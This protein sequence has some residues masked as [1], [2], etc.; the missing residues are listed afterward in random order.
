MRFVLRTLTYHAGNLCG[1]KRR[2]H[3][4][5]TVRW[6]RDE[7]DRSVVV[8]DGPCGG[9]R[10]RSAHLPVG[11]RRRVVRGDDHHHVVRSP[12]LVRPNTVSQTLQVNC[13]L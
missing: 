4:P 2:R 8:L 9:L 1:G 7:W 5:S 13:P 11:E 6:A 3:D 10:D 12:P